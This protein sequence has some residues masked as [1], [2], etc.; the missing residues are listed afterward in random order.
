MGGPGNG[1]I[2]SLLEVDRAE[3]FGAYR[4]GNI[5]HHVRAEQQGRRSM[6][7]WDTRHIVVDNRVSLLIQHIA[8]LAK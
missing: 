8:L 6:G 2:Q 7:N 4:V 1:F 3:E 5:T